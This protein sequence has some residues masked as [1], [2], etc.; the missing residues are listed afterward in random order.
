[1]Q[2]IVL[3]VLI[4]AHNPGKWLHK[5][6]N[7]LDTQAENYRQTEIIVVDDGST[8]DLSWIERDYPS[9]RY[10]RTDNH[11]D[12]HARNVLLSEAKGQY[13]QFL[14]ADDEIYPHALDIIYSNIAQGYDY[15]SYEF[16]TDHDPKRSFHNYGQIMVNCPVWAYTFRKD[17]IGG[18]RFDESFQCSSD[19]DWLSRVLKEKSKSKHDERV[20]YNYRFDGND[21]SLSHQFLRGEIGK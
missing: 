20:F 1:M 14:D 16:D 2:D 21:G 18:E 19:T 11:G 8:E 15:V 13:I 7:S 3:S 17:Y 5:L 10:I 4:P 9:V 12:A 6:I